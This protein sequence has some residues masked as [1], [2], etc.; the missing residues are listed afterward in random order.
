[1]LE[2]LTR[3]F[4]PLVVAVAGLCGVPEMSAQFSGAGSGTQNDPYL[5][6]NP[7]HL[8]QV[9]NY[10]DRTDVWFSLQSDIDLGS[11]IAT[12]APGEGWSPIGTS[13]KPFKGHFIGNKHTVKGLH[14]N[15]ASSYQ[16]LFASISNG[17]I[18]GLTIE[19][20]VTA[21]GYVGLLAGAI[22]TSTRLSDCHAKGSLTAHSEVAGGLAGYFYGTA[23]NCR[24]EG[25]VSGTTKVGGLFGSVSNSD[26]SGCR[27]DA[28]VSGT[29]ST[30]GLIGSYVQSGTSPYSVTHC[31]AKS[32]ITGESGANKYFGGLIG[33]LYGD[34]SF[35]KLTS[36]PEPY[37]KQ[38]VNIHNCGTSF[39]IATT[40]QA[41]RGVGGL[42]GFSASKTEEVTRDSYYHSY[43]Y[44]G[45]FY[46]QVDINGC[47]ALGNINSPVSD[48]VGGLV[49]SGQIT[50]IDNSY[51]NGSIT[52]RDNIGGVIGY[53]KESLTNQ[54]YT[55]ADRTTAHSTIN[56][57]YAMASIA[58]REYVGGI[59]GNIVDRGTVVT[60]NFALNPVLSAS[61]GKVA[62]ISPVSTNY[63]G[64]LGS[65]SSN[66]CLTGAKVSA[67][68]VEQSFSTNLFNGNQSGME[69]MMLRATYQ[70]L[71]WDFDTEWAI[72]ETECYPYKATQCAP[73]IIQSEPTSGSI[74]VSGKSLSGGRVYMTYCGQ[75]YS[76]ECNGN[77]WTVRTEPMKPG[78]T[79]TVWA[80]SDDLLPSYAVISYVGYPGSGTADDPY[81]IFTANDLQNINGHAYYK[82][83]NDIDLSGTEWT[84][85]G[86]NGTS[87]AGFDGS[88]FAIKG[89]TIAKGNG[90]AYCGLFS[91][92]QNATISNLTIENAAISGTDYCGALAGSARNTTVRNV[93]VVNSTVT[94][95]GYCGGLVGEAKATTATLCV[96]NGN[97]TCSGTHA[98]GIFATADKASS[99][100]CS[101]TSGTING[102][103]DS[104]TAA[105]LVAELRGTVTDCFS[106][107]NLTSTGY[108]AGVAATNFGSVANCY[109]S[110]NLT[111]D[112]LAGGLV[113][114]NDG[115]DASLSHSVAANE[116]ISISSQTG[117]GMRV[118]AGSRNGAKL[119]ATG[120]N[121]A[122]ERMI[123]SVNG[124][125][126][127][128]YEDPMNGA[129]TSGDLLRQAKTYQE[130]GWNFTKTWTLTGSDMPQLKGIDA[131]SGSER[132]DN[133]M[134]VA[135]TKTAAG[136]TFNMVIN[137]RNNDA[138]NGYQFDI[139]L[140]E[141]FEVEYD[142][143]FEEYNYTK[144]SRMT[145]TH[146]IVYKA[147]PDGSVRFICI[148]RSAENNLTGDDGDIISL[149]IVVAP[150]AINGTYQFIL[151]NIYLS[152]G[153]SE[154]VALNKVTGRITV[155]NDIISVDGVAIMAGSKADLNVT[156][157]N[158][159]AINSFQFDMYLPEG[160]EI[161]DNAL[162]QPDL[163][164][165]DRIDTKQFTIAS[166]RQPDGS[167]R[168]IVFGNSNE[169]IISGNTGTIF[170]IGLACGKDATPAASQVE[171][172]NIYLSDTQMRS[173]ECEPATAAITIERFRRKGDV[174]TDGMITSTDIVGTMTLVMATE[175]TPLDTWA[176]D[177]NDDGD[178]KSNDVKSVTE[179][180]LDEKLPARVRAHSPR[181]K[182]PEDYGYT[183]N[184]DIQLYASPVAIN[185]GESAEM[186]LNL[187]NTQ[188]DRPSATNWDVYLPEGF[189][190]NLF[191]DPQNEHDIW[192]QNSRRCRDFMFL[193]RIVESN[194]V[195]MI[196]NDPMAQGIKG[197]K[198]EM[199]RLS[200]KADASVKPGVYTA[201]IR[202]METTT[203]NNGDFYTDPE[204]FIIIVGDISAVE[205]LPLAGRIADEDITLVE[206]ALHGNESLLTVDLSENR[207]LPDGLL[208]ES[209]NPNTLVFTTA[210]RKV[211]TG[212][213]VVVDGVCEDFILSDNHPFGTDRAFTAT[214]AAY[215][216][217]L[218]PN[219]NETLYIPFKA[220]PVDGLFYSVINRIDE[221]GTVNVRVTEQDAHVPVMMHA[222]PGSAVANGGT[223][224]FNA[225]NVEIAPETEPASE[226]TTT[227]TGS[228][229]FT[230]PTEARFGY[231][232]GTF[233]KAVRL[234]PFRAYAVDPAVENLPTGIENVAADGHTGEDVIF[235]LTGIRI[236]ADRNSLLPGFYIINGEKVYVK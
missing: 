134:Y 11:W 47:F 93:Q 145:R 161:A 176:A 202:D 108:T 142:E 123:I 38:K 171:L 154:A 196:N 79:I 122:L 25:A 143:E 2:S 90:A 211:A 194:H 185:P 18:K 174:N 228:Y 19:G 59:I 132:R 61:V 66:Y 74:V 103:G 55:S 30:G 42:I 98:A 172:R 221:Q 27:T 152:R 166:K 29:E 51:F 167:M 71:G 231:S 155:L 129:T 205:H 224:T 86:L 158:K 1:M 136:Q 137:L 138:V 115:T 10:V 140:P 197:T 9:R 21:N 187:N 135:D 89:L 218:A 206:T 44:S 157:E 212:N 127:Q 65:T 62:R 217:T 169:T 87:V 50:D 118:L 220:E 168:V 188:A 234:E 222:T 5:I 162:G 116:Q 43:Y 139:Q 160:V 56:R 7:I 46:T 41:G 170:T 146:S 214:H 72:Q 95:S 16:G 39:H 126:Q 180:A 151:K 64:E 97:L 20:D 17:D 153:I 144:G 125:A 110:G 49:G 33:Y 15:R 92:L 14:I 182:K 215:S 32:T 191:D 82:L 106:S 12:N 233:N 53:I 76:A 40:Q 28:T 179:L 54:T 94:G 165:G 91:T 84:P 149:P 164:L 3:R 67:N 4:A 80:E 102:T 130:M 147:Q 189:S 199:M 104:T 58:G 229:R 100:E 101:C 24:F 121:L 128:I 156:L 186:V 235:T 198:G 13:E 207:E 133:Y 107:A 57:C 31:F 114:Y 117:N 111:S 6:F 178:I 208:L 73:P 232:D 48:E 63:F 210:D 201:W 175:S 96:F 236:H 225:S 184:E 60:S 204:P 34:Y 35:Y 36:E 8:N 124:V 150:D 213:N 69:T 230:S 195:K 219:A 163:R 52:G 192:Y 70:G 209:L 109:A 216:R 26:I 85:I 193:A 177:V 200:L 68:G 183:R 99:V 112:T 78:E 226:S 159:S 203:G 23:N 148:P 37:E 227:L 77:T 141:G 190:L 45:T 131:V 83:M 223:V 181:D 173:F 75:T 81:Q 119:P 105:G 120:D 113:A 88:G 22:D